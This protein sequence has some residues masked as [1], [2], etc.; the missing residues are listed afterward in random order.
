MGLGLGVGAYLSGPGPDL[1]AEADAPMI[2]HLRV[3]EKWR[4]YENAEDLDF[5]RQLAQPDLF[6][7]DPGT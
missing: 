5:L 7:E 1:G 6:G 3:A 2:R 4:F